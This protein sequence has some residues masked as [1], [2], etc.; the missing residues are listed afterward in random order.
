MSIRKHGAVATLPFAVAAAA[1]AAPSLAF[2]EEGRW[3]QHPDPQD[4]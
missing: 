1:L 2:A 4:V 3:I